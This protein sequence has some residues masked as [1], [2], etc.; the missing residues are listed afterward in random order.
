M[1]GVANMLKSYY[2]IEVSESFLDCMNNQL[3]ILFPKISGQKLIQGIWMGWQQES[4]FIYDK[5]TVSKINADIFFRY[6]MTTVDILWKSKS[7]NVYEISD[8]NINCEDIEFWFEGLDADK[9]KNLQSAKWTLLTFTDHHIKEF[10]KVYNLDVS[11]EFLQCLNKQLSTFFENLL[12]IKITGNTSLNLVKNPFD[13]EFLDGLKVCRFQ[14]V[15]YIHHNWNPITIVWQSKSGRIYSVEDKDIG[16]ED[17]EFRFETFDIDL[18][19]K[20][21]P[22]SKGQLP[23]KLKNLSF[24]LTSHV[25]NVDCL[26]SIRLKDQYNQDMDGIIGKL[27]KFVEEFNTVSEQA[28]RKNGVVHNCRATILNDSMIEFDVDLGSAGIFFLKKLLAF[29][30]KMEVFEEVEIGA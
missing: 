18:Y 27:Y 25:I 19:R 29:M 24:E 15:L 9:C 1:A 10:R 3:S 6:G 8:P 11:F 16:Y 26:V 12:G 7:G 28:N 2:S 13:Q 4:L 5:G 30:S 21:L 14:S 17:L 20:Q 22:P 23:F